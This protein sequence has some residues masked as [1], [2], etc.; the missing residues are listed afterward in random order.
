MRPGELAG[1]RWEDVDFD[2]GVISVR[3]SLKHSRGKL[4]QGD[5]KTQQSRSR[6]KALPSSMRSPDDCRGLGIDACLS[7]RGLL[8][9]AGR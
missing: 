3:R 6:F 7:V 1:L 9:P 2:T 5:T 4:W 8:R